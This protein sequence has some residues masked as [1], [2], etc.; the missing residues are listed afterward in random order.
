MGP[1]DLLINDLKGEILGETPNSPFTS[2]LVGSDSTGPT[3]PGSARLA[4]V[5]RSLHLGDR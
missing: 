3:K 4:S 2:A 5:C 1:Y